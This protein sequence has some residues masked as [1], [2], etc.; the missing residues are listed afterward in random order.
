MADIRTCEVCAKPF[1]MRQRNRANRFCSLACY[2]A[3][4]PRGARKADVVGRQRTVPNHPLAPPSG[5]V[6]VARLVL[7]DKIGPGPHTCHWCGN[8]V[9]WMPGSG[10]AP[11]ALVVD[12]LDFDRA[13]DSPENLVPSCNSCNAH[14]TRNGDRRSI[15]DGE[16]TIM[17]SGGTRTR[18]VERQCQSC[19]KSF[20]V[21]LS[22]VKYRASSGTYCSRGCMY[23]ALAEKYKAP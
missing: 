15:K 8:E 6:V 4:G 16:L 3:A 21:A 14:R 2:Y 23:S 9:R 13:N 19:G 22:Q 12:H 5:M 1:A 10:L 18:A 17:Q 11:G 20:L 7:Y